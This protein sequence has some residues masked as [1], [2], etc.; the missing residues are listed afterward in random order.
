MQHALL[1]LDASHFGVRQRY[2]PSVCSL[3]CCP[4]PLCPEL[5]VS[6]TPL[7]AAPSVAV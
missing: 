7:H 6:A 3:P 4:S 5:I 2:N 1:Q